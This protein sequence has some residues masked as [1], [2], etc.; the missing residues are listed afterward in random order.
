MDISKI[1]F[2]IFDTFG[3]VVDW[4]GQIVEEGE[5]LGR[6]YDFVID[7]HKFANDWRMSYFDA[8][9]A[10]A[11]GTREWEKIDSVFEKIMYELLDKYKIIGIIPEEELQGFSTVWHRLKGWDDTVEGL[12]RLKSKYMIGPFTNGDFRL[13][14]DMAKNADLNWDFIITADIFKKFKPDPSI[15]VDVVKFLDVDPEEVMMVAAHP[16]DLDGAVE[17]GCAT[18]YVTRPEE[19]GPDSGYV[20]PAGRHENDVTLPDFNALADYLGV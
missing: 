3:T 11:A 19:F 13:I 7:W 6:K 10:I 1:K 2:L 17:V 9:R 18:A 12:R 5:V 14:L 8:T 4:H 16:F 15:Y 20:E